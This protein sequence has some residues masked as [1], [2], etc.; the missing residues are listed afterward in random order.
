MRG[1]ATFLLEVIMVSIMATVSIAFILI[2]STR[3]GI[4]KMSASFSSETVLKIEKNREKI[5]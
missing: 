2:P 5:L 4:S 3:K 1:N